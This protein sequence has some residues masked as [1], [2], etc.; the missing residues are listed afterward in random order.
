[1]CWIALFILAGRI[2][3][4]TTLSGFFTKSSPTRSLLKR[5]Y[6]GSKPKTMLKSPRLLLPVSVLSKPQP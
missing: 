1:M 3:R 6:S 2:T 5:Y 4:F